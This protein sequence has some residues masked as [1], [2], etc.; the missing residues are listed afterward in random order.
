MSISTK[1][2]DDGTTGLLFNRRV[3]KDHPRIEAY[4]TCD[5]FNAV[6]GMGR[7]LVAQSP[8]SPKKTWVGEQLHQIQKD[9]VVLMGELALLPEDRQRYQQAGHR[10]IVTGDV[11][12][13]TDLV[14]EMEAEDPRCDGWATPGVCPASAA[15][16]MARAVCRRSERRVLSL[17]EDVRKSNPD[18]IHYLNRLSDVLWLM[19]RRVEMDV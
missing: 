17:G 9:L 19:A 15:L 12:R 6:L 18:V 13:L 14:H 5:E 7:A 1:T 4:S 8:S 3:R 11:E 16:H 10:L 2:G